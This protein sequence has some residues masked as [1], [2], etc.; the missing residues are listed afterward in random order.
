MSETRSVTTLQAAQDAVAHQREWFAGLRAEVEAGAP[1]AVVNADSPH[2]LFRAFGVPYV[3]NQWWA[4]IV[5]AKQK[6]GQYLA[7]LRERGY[8][9]WTDQYGSLALASSLAADDDPPWGGL[10]RP[11]FLVAHL[12]DDAQ[13]KIFEL[14]ARE[15]GAAF[16]GLASTVANTI[17]PSW[18]KR[19][20]HEWEDVIGS[21]RLDLMVEELG[22]LVGLIERRPGAGTTRR[23]WP[24]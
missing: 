10:P 14:W 21:D 2:E 6:S 20:Q 9:D 13:R 18:H 7:V 19:I 16:F 23:G 11:T 3:V 8:P 1:L 12:T 5:A 15:S 4:S 17:P 22:E 24:R